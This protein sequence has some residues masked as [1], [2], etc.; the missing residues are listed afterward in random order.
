MKSTFKSE[1]GEEIH[2][3]LQFLAARFRITRGEEEL[4]EQLGLL[5]MPG[6][7]EEDEH[8]AFSLGCLKRYI[9]LKGLTQ[10]DKATGD[11]KNA[12]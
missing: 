3:E 11:K 7:L 5:L 10:K 1:E 4:G 9:N 8:K 12:K 6:E 2:I